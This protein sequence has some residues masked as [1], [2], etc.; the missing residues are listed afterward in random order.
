MDQFNGA[1]ALGPSGGGATY[2]ALGLVEAAAHDGP[3]LVDVVAQS[4]EEAAAP[5]LQWMG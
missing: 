5:V 1:E 3:A 4:L 2:L